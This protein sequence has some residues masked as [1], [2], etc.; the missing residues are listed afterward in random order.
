ML[1]SCAPVEGECKWPSELQDACCHITNVN[2]KGK[3][4][5]CS[6]RPAAIRGLPG[7]L[8][9]LAC[10]S[11]RLLNSCLR[12]VV[13]SRTG[14]ALANAGMPWAD[15]RDAAP[16]SS[17]P[18]ST[19]PNPA[20]T[21][22]KMFFTCLDRSGQ[23]A[24]Y[25]PFGIQPACRDHRNADILL[26]TCQMD[27]RNCILIGNPSANLVHSINAASSLIRAAPCMHQSLSSL[28]LSI[29]LADC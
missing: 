13:I 12:G 9:G 11:F 15:L 24:H 3:S 5:C 16:A 2:S 19:L 8:R 20:C 14:A 23:P 25:S 4:P 28:H 1:G 26:A 10:W 22:S 29:F 21:A 27:S 17:G 7:A 6:G 18:S